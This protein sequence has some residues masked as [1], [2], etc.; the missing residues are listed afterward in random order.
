MSDSHT[1][2]TLSRRTFAVWLPAVALASRAT[3]AM[4]QSAPRS[5]RM[6]NSI[7]EEQILEQLRTG[8]VMSR[9]PVG[10]TSVN[11]ACDLAGEIDMAFK[12]RST[13]HGEA[14]LSEI[15]AFRLNR[16]LGMSRV[17]PACSRVMPRGSL[18]LP[19][20]TPVVAERDG[21]VRGA[22]IYWC[23]VLRDSRIDQERE[24][25]RWTSW[26][27]QRGALADADRARAEEVS[28]LI[29]FDV[30]TGNW[31]RWSGSNVPMDGTGHLIY[32]DNNG[33]FSEPFGER[34]MAG[35]MRHLRPVQRF[36]RSFIE[37]ARA[38][39]EASVRAEMALDGDPAH[40]PLN[41]TQIASLLRRRDALVAHVDDLVRRNSAESVLCFA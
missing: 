20:E 15:A 2:Y 14:Y 37:R 7:A 8:R 22:A 25:S 41:A 30:L 40:P 23:P 36:S 31:D 24:R 21:S 28:S 1:P 13:S 17:P 38:L 12:P 11:Y 5:G 34:M 33:G 3:P 26:L 6:F 4:A 27:R 9:R 29:A 19:R 39:T 32:L 18:R 35:V 10:S 16:M